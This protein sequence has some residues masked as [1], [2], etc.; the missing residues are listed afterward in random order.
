MGPDEGWVFCRD[1]VKREASLWS[2]RLVLMLTAGGQRGWSCASAALLLLLSDFQT[3]V[4]A[5]QSDESQTVKRS[6]LKLLLVLGGR[7]TLG[8]LVHVPYMMLG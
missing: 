7:D 3:R 6:F 5:L 8:L 2:L 4:L 1:A